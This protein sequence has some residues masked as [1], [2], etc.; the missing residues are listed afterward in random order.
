MPD[1]VEELGSQG[2]VQERLTLAEFDEFI[3]RE[4]RTLRKP[5]RDSGIT[6][7]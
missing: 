6:P 1:V 2:L 5:V 7:E 4:V 3:A